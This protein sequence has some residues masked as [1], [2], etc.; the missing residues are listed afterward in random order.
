MADANAKCPT[1]R[2]ALNADKPPPTFPFCNS[3]CKAADLG[4]WLDGRYVIAGPAADALDG[5]L[6]EETLAALIR[7]NS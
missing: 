1:C 2:R 4:N 5:E 7:E 6:D 3:R